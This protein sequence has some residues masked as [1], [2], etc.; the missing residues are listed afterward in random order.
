[1]L[2]T[3]LAFRLCKK[4]NTHTKRDNKSNLSLFMIFSVCLCVI[5]SKQFLCLNKVNAITVFLSAFWS[6][7]CNIQRFN[8]SIQYMQRYSSNDKKKLRQQKSINTATN[9]TDQITQYSK[10]FCLL[11]KFLPFGNDVIAAVFIRLVSSL[12]LSHCA[13]IVCQIRFPSILKKYLPLK[14]IFLRIFLFI[15]EFLFGS[16]INLPKE[17]FLFLFYLLFIQYIHIERANKHSNTQKNGV[18]DSSERKIVEFEWSYFLIFVIM[19]K[20]KAML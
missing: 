5:F 1:M 16:F 14:D 7:F 15:L 12:R 18:C 13:V 6:Y 8:A 10:Y 2:I 4:R 20:N 11:I 17:H 9:S 19:K 3:Q